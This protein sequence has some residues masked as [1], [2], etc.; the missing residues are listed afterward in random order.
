MEIERSNWWYSRQET[1]ME[2]DDGDDA[3]FSIVELKRKM[4]AL[5]NAMDKAQL[6]AEELSREI[7]AIEHEIGEKF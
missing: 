4:A 5:N 1:R 7:V 2:E 6:L 3:W